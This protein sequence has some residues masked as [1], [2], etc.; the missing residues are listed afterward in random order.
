MTLRKTY[1]EQRAALN[2]LYRAQSALAASHLLYEHELFQKS[3]HIACYIAFQQEF[4]TLP[5]MELIWSAG[6]ICYLP[7]LS[8]AKTLQFVQHN[9]GDELAL[10]QYG[11]LEPQSQHHS[12]APE[13]LDLVIM[14]LVAF[15][16]KGN[17]LGT[18]GG[19]YDR[20][21][22]FL[23]SHP[24]PA[25]FLLGLGFDSQQCEQIEMEPWDVKLNGMLTE[26][27]LIKF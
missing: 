6:K 19:Y 2:S 21:F 7:V 18:G 14:P 20:T 9:A 10:N 8:E 3:R 22:A 16:L 17:R 26:S 12:I 4:S 15:D 23:S 25:P 27:H 11:I 13:K 5:L 24:S 1:R